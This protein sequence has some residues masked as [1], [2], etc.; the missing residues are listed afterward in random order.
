MSWRQDITGLVCFLSH[1]NTLDPPTEYWIENSDGGM[2]YGPERTGSGAWCLE[3]AEDM[4]MRL[5]LYT[6]GDETYELRGSDPCGENDV[7]PH[8]STCGKT[9]AGW[10]SE[11]CL[12]DELNYFESNL[13]FEPSP[14]NLHVIY[15]ALW[16]FQW[17]EDSDDLLRWRAVGQLAVDK[18]SFSP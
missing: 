6:P 4:V 10:P 5:N 14:E 18:I 3:H 15:M 13:D 1:H 7:I 9:L 2:E 8:C 17:E 16:N 11:Y 12:T